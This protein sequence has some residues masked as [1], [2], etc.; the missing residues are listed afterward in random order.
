[1]RTKVGATYIIDPNMSYNFQRQQTNN[2]NTPYDYSSI[3]HYDRTAFS[4]VPGQDSI[5]PI[6]NPNFMRGQ[7]LGISETDILRIN[8]LYNCWAEEDL[9]SEEKFTTA[10][11][12]SHLKEY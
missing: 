2:L 5:T 11:H 10:V 12:I 3:M 1:M 9:K 6:P 7:N 8:K 4:I